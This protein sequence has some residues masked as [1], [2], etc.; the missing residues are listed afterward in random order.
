[1]NHEKLA[2]LAQVPRA[3]PPE[4]EAAIKPE[5][6]LY[7]GGCFVVLAGGLVTLVCA[8]LAVF[9]VIGWPFIGIGLGLMIIGKLVQVVIKP[10][11]LARARKRFAEM[12]L[13]LGAVVQANRRLYEPG[14][15]DVLPTIVVYI[16][17]TDP[18][19]ANGALVLEASARLQQ[20]RAQSTSDAALLPLVQKML[21][22]RSHFTNEP[23]PESLMRGTRLRW[24]IMMMDSRRL[25]KG[26]LEEG[27]VLPLFVSDRGPWLLPAAL[28]I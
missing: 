22:E 16:D 18:Q 20:L 5:G 21:D 4:L 23:L 24:S 26:H 25:P 7:E 15:G 6:G 8:A 11:A 12:P 28:Y 1:M 27:Q 19:V 17:P 13:T 10:S 14:P 9:G 3:V 2:V